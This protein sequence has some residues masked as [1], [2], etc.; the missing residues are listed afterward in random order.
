M[1]TFSGTHTL[2]LGASSAIGATIAT[3]LGKAG[4]QVTGTSRQTK[5]DGSPHVHLDLAD[6]ASI[7]SLLERLPTTPHYVVD[8]LHTPCE[9]LIAGTDPEISQQWFAHNC[10][11]KARLLHH[12]S[13]AM[14]AQRKGRFIYI[15]STAAALPNP[16]QG[17]YAATKQACE[18]LYNSLGIELGTRGITACTLRPGYVDAGRGETYL[19]EHP[20]V[21]KRI[22]LGRAS[23]TQEVAKTVAF[24]LSDCAVSFNATALTMD[25]GLTA[26]K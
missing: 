26:C 5:Q 21:T 17:F 7:D 6:D 1:L 19:Q 22:P 2:V 20:E 9:G 23:T 24:L 8:C 4:L 18:A 11:A 12:L 16:G 13:R 25:G 15:S 3:V 10:T 14:L